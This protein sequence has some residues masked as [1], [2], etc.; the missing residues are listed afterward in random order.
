LADQIQGPSKQLDRAYK[1]ARPSWTST[2]TG[3]RKGKTR[4]K[5]AAKPA[6]PPSLALDSGAA[7]S[8][9]RV[10]ARLT[11]QSPR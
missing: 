3:S 2:A 6:A 8:S 7:C 1:K 4:V 11:Q 5:P 10:S 9:R